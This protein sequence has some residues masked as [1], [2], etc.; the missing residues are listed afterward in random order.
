MTGSVQATGLDE[1][2]AGKRWTGRGCTTT[3]SDEQRRAGRRRRAATG[4]DEGQGRATLED[5]QPALKDEQ[6]GD[7][8]RRRVA[9]EDGNP[10]LDDG[11]CQRTNSARGQAT[12]D[13]QRQGRV[14]DDAQTATGTLTRRRTPTRRAH[15]GRAHPDDRMPDAVF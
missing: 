6:P 5:G 10:A 7:G 9:T 2:R 1:R 15:D 13:G 11:Q 14:T 8:Q 3:S 12:P 4:K